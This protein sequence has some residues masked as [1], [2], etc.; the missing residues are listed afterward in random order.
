VWGYET[1]VKIKLALYSEPFVFGFILHAIAEIANCFKNIVAKIIVLAFFKFTI[2][3]KAFFLIF[4]INDNVFP[5]IHIVI[6]TQTLKQNNYSIRFC[7]TI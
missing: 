5:F 1:V 2:T 4:S 7:I 3:N 6:P